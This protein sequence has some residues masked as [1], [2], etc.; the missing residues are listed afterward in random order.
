MWLL[1]R[2]P[3]PLK[4]EKLDLKGVVVTCRDRGF[5]VAKRIR[6]LY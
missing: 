3:N 5:R 4:K 1:G 6:V 2:G